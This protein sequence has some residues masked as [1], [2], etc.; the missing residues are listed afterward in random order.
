[1]TRRAHLH[2]MV[3]A[4]GVAAAVSGCGSAPPPADERARGADA[5]RHYG[6]GTCHRIPGIAGATGTVGPSLERFHRQVYIAGFI[7]NTPDAL[8]QWI[9]SPKKFDPRTAM[10]EMGVS[11]AEARLIAEF[12]SR[13]P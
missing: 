8:A 11:A 4:A 7:P 12:L 5:I 10:P 13:S 2:G 3:L 1:M 9:E 6:C